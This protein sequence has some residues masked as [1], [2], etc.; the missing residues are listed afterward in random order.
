VCNTKERNEDHLSFTKSR[1]NIRDAGD[2][3]FTA[4]KLQYVII[5]LYLTFF[6][7]IC[8]CKQSLVQYNIK[9]GNRPKSFISCWD[10]W[11]S[12]PWTISIIFVSDALT[13]SC[14]TGDRRDRM[15]LGF[16]TN[17]NIDIKFSAHGTF[18]EYASSSTLKIKRF[19]VQSVTTTTN[20]VRWN[21]AHSEVYSI[22]H[23]VCRSLATGLWFSLGSPVS[24]TNK[25]DR[26][27]ITE[28][29][30]KVP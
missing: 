7:I 6:C 19:H 20:A 25:T 12:V 1:E 14:T 10:I 27:D 26:Y 30:L 24:S 18:L 9:S 21:H 28:L 22:Q 13:S 23:Q 15:V 4:C 2:E 3:T 17:K 29:L 16:I 11:S 8:H 5:I